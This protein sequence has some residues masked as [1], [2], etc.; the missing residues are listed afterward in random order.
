MMARRS[1]HVNI[2]ACVLLVV[3]LLLALAVFSH[4]PADLAGRCLPAPSHAA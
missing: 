4:D 1:W 2:A 3:G